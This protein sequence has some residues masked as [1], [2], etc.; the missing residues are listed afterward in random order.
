MSV[1]PEPVFQK[2]L[3]KISWKKI[4]SRSYG[5]SY[6]EMAILCISPKAKFLIPT[7][8]VDHIIIPDGEN[9]AFYVDKKTWNNLVNSLDKKYAQHIDRLENYEKA[10]ID[11]GKKYVNFAKEIAKKKFSNMPISKLEKIYEQYQKKLFRYSTYV[12][13]AFILNNFVADRAES[14]ID[15][16]LT[17]KSL[18]QKK[19][20]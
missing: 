9:T 16:Y 14:I 17:T 8:S 15:Q 2:K 1:L 12:W 3:S 7:P 10:V 4:Y 13:T 5:V 19:P 11:N 18:R 6:S 20:E